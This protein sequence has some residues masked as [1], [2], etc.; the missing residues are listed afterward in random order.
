M[1]IITTN[2]PQKI[3]NKGSIGESEGI[4]GQEWLPRWDTA[5]L[6]NHKILFV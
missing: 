1:V 6:E 3:S 2:N 5:V 4:S